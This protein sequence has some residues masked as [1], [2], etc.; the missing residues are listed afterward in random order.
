MILSTQPITR[1]ALLIKIFIKSAFLFLLLDYYFLGLT[2][3]IVYVGAI[4]ILFLFVIMMA[5]T[6]VTPLKSTKN[7]LITILPNSLNVENTN[8]N[9]S[10]KLRIP[11]SS[12]GSINSI[13]GSATHLA[14]GLGLEYSRSTNTLLSIIL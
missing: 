10:Y 5:E 1:L 6:H 11:S 7:E 3:I 8:L 13:N 14:K 2:Y 9:N 4:A 12:M